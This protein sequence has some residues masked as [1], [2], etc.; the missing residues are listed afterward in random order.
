MEEI[1]Y[2]IKTGEDIELYFGYKIKNED[3][4]I[5]SFIIKENYNIEKN[6]IINYNCNNFNTFY[7]DNPNIKLN[8]FN[9]KINDKNEISKIINF[10]YNDIKQINEDELIKIMVLICVKNIKNIKYKVNDHIDIINFIYNNNNFIIYFL[11]TSVENIFRISENIEDEDHEKINLLFK[12]EILKND[13]K[14][15]EKIKNLYITINNTSTN[16]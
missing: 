1:E 4:I 2:N 13:D 14:N 12:K 15:Y 5:E 8:V 7:P 6:V 9:E 16:Y 10:E 11:K 3:N